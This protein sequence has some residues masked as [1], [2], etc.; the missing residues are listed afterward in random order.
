[1]LGR[2]CSLNL[3]FILNLQMA[4]RLSRYDSKINGCKKRCIVL[5]NKQRLLSRLSKG[6]SIVYATFS[7]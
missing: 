4:N 5:S 7:G 6:L 2:I 1:M 3:L